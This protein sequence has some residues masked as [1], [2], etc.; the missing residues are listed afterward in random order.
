MKLQRLL[1]ERTCTGMYGINCTEFFL[2][3]KFI[4]YGLISISNTEKKESLKFKVDSM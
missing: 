1:G 2:K 3:I 4:V